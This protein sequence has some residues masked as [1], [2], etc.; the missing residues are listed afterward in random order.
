MI[1]NKIFKKI[2]VKRLQ[3]TIGPELPSTCHDGSMVSSPYGDGVILVGCSEHSN[4]IYRLI[5]SNNNG[6]E[7]SL[8][9]RTMPITLQYPRDS[10]VAILIPDELTNCA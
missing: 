10:T 2:F 9:W 4:A 8:E 5:A 1:L 3:N 6:I 7:M